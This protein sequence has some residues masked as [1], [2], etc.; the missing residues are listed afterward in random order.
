LA[1]GAVV[2]SIGRTANY[3]ADI[4]EMAIDL[5]VMVDPKPT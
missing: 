3:A 4:A 5:A 2:D 1:L